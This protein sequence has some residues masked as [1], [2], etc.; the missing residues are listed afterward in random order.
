MSLNVLPRGAN[1]GSIGMTPS[2][3]GTSK[4]VPFVDDNEHQ[5]GNCGVCESD[6]GHGLVVAG[7]P[8]PEYAY[9]GA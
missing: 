5:A 4:V 7:A 3:A 1:I 6:I 2:A 8:D 9:G